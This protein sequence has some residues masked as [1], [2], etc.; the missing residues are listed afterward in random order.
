VRMQWKL[1]IIFTLL[2]LFSMQFIG[3]YFYQNLKAYYL[4]NFNV[5]I[6][7]QAQFLSYYLEPYLKPGSYQGREDLF[8]HDIDNLIGNLTTLHGAQVQVVDRDGVVLATTEEEKWIVGQK[9]NQPEVGRALNGIKEESIYALSTTGERVKMIV[10]PVKEGGQTLGAVILTASLEEVYG[11]IQRISQIFLTGTG[12]ALGLTA[13]I[14]IVIARTI[15]TPIREVTKQATAMA[16]GDFS[17]KVPVKSADEIG[18]L[19]IAFNHLA[20]QLDKAITENLEERKKLASILANMSEG[21]IAIDSEGKII[22]MNPSARDMLKQKE[23]WE[24]RSIFECLRLPK[25][26]EYDPL[27]DEEGSFLMDVPISE[28]KSLTLRVTISPIKISNDQQRGAIVVLSDVTEQEK[29][30]RERKEFVANVSHELRTP[31]TTMK[32]YLESLMDGAIDDPK[33]ARSFIQVVQNETERMIRLVSDL[34]LL[35]RIDYK[36]APLNLMEIELNELVA[37]ALNRFTFQMKKQGIRANLHSDKPI[38][39]L[40]DRDKMHQVFDNLISNAIKYSRDHGEI[41]ISIREL[42]DHWIEVEIADQGIGIPE[43]DLERIFERFYRVDKARSRAM[44]GTGLGL[45][46][47]SEIVQLHGGKI[48]IESQ[49]DVGTTIHLLL[50][51]K[52]ERKNHVG[53]DQDPLIG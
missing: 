9:N 4:N 38:W 22:L 40:L 46:I 45:S 17:R 31:L 53:T 50:P 18:K 51:R 42:E 16:E 8:L 21:V 36:E 32:S 1:V 2:I 25:D 27:F 29:M 12:I 48:Q 24:D 47:A 15:T 37:E 23:D 26:M 13:M 35:S 3:A 28:K 11:T 20:S 30:D 6:N 14:G 41:N 49:L 19:G 33:L 43:Q 44:G 52:G 5:S 7:S 10:L 39:I 34:L